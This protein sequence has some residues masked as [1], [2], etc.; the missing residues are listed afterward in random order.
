MR[1]RTNPHS[2]TLQPVIA[3]ILGALI[4]A[5]SSSATDSTVPKPLAEASTDRADTA[6]ANKSSGIWQTDYK[7]ALV[8]AAKEDKQVLLD[9]TGSDWCPYCVRMDKEVLNQPDFKTFAT[10]KLILVKL[11]FPRRKQ[12]PPAEAEQNQK[13][14]EEFAIEGFPTYV[15]LDPAGKEVRRQVGYLEGGPR[16]FIK[17]AQAGN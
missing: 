16:E 5:G 10:N 9:F 6:G 3:A 15:L 7:Q 14:Q 17:W 4:A 1:S 12:I 8:E 11:D 2:S 13:L